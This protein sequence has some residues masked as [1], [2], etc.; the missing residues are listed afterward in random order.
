MIEALQTFFIIVC[1]ACC[2]FSLAGVLTAFYSFFVGQ[3]TPASR[4]VIAHSF[5][6]IILSL[7]IFLTACNMTAC[8]KNF[9]ENTWFWSA[10]L[11]SLLFLILKY[12]GIIQ[13]N[14]ITLNK[15]VFRI[16]LG[17]LIGFGIFGAISQLAEIISN[18][19][20]SLLLFIFLLLFFSKELFVLT[21]IITISV[22]I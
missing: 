19:D 12:I 11:F 21:A 18:I 14:C 9:V 4:S 20:A 8:N 17:L 2:L 6:V 13:K 7:F 1:F 10:V 3:F 22:L 16:F 15:N 5:I